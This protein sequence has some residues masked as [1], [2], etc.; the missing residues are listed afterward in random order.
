MRPGRWHRL[1]LATLL[2]LPGTLALPAAASAAPTAAADQCVVNAVSPKDPT[3]VSTM[4]C[5]TSFRAAITYATGGRITD[6]P[7]NART[8]AKSKKF[9]A[10]VNSLADSVTPLD[11][12]GSGGILVAIEYWDI[13]YGDPS[14][15]VWGSHACSATYSDVDYYLADLRQNGRGWNDKISSLYGYNHCWQRLYE[16]IGFGGEYVG[17]VKYVSDLRNFFFN[18][19]ASSIRF[20]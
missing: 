15:V 1:A 7:N 17:W 2:T 3:Q 12:A 11:S 5:F 14:L 18:D 4:R 20:T 16:H 13:G 6:A 9:T 19:R 10:R 8:A